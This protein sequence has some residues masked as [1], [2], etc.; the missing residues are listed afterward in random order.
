MA[1]PISNLRHYDGYIHR[2][3]SKA[4]AEILSLD[5]DPISMVCPDAFLI[6]S[7]AERQACRNSQRTDQECSILDV[8]TDEDLL[9]VIAEFK[10]SLPNVSAEIE[11]MNKEVKGLAL[12]RQE[13]EDIVRT[14]RGNSAAI[15]NKQGKLRLPPPEEP[16]GWSKFIA[17]KNP[18]P[19]KSLFLLLVPKKSVEAAQKLCDAYELASQAREG[20]VAQIETLTRKNTTLKSD[21]DSKQEEIQKLET[22]QKQLKGLKKHKKTLDQGVK[23]LEKNANKLELYAKPKQRTQTVAQKQNEEDDDLQFS[24]EM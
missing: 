18:G 20:L 12:L 2:W 19:F 11:R 8:L 10:K 22:K 23:E 13:H 14:M 17:D 21:L 7:K 4:I 3:M 6:L 1:E 5:E 24:M 15:S 9:E 16:G